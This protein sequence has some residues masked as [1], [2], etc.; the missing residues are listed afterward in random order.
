MPERWRNVDVL[1]Q[2]PQPVPMEHV[3]QSLVIKEEITG[4]LPPGDRSAVR[5]R[6]L[7]RLLLMN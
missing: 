1:N 5:E 7:D 6:V 4:N 3:R 2:Q